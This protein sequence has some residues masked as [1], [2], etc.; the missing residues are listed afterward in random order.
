MSEQAF[1][2]Y[3]VLGWGGWG[4]LQHSCYEIRSDYISEESCLMH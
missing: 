3:H 4:V 1:S 2:P